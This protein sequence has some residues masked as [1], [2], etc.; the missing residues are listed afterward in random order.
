M[1]SSNT[2]IDQATGKVHMN[3]GR[4][5]IGVDTRMC[6]GEERVVA[7]C[8]DTN[9]PPPPPAYSPPAPANNPQG[10]RNPQEKSRANPRPMRLHA[11]QNTDDDDTDTESTTTDTDTDTDDECCRDLEAGALSTRRISQATGAYGSGNWLSPSFLCIVI[12]CMIIKILILLVIW[13]LVCCHR[14]H[15]CLDS[16]NGIGE[17]DPPMPSPHDPSP[18]M[19]SPQ[20]SQN[21]HQM[22]PWQLIA[23]RVHSIYHHQTQEHASHEISVGQYIA[24]GLLLSVL[25]GCASASG[26][27]F[28]V[29][30]SFVQIHQ[31]RPA[32][33]TSRPSSS[34]QSS[35]KSSAMRRFL[36]WLVPMPSRP[37]RGQ[38][39]RRHHNPSTKNPHAQQP[40]ST[41][42]SNALTTS[43]HQQLNGDGP[44]PIPVP[45]VDAT[46]PLRIAWLAIFL[47]AQ[48]A[49]TLA[50]ILL[51]AC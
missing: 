46:T 35:Q 4:W 25:G 22:R 43:P 50:F 26:L 32:S 44:R 29:F 9:S 15:P 27:L 24:A 33:S 41:P 38:G 23:E 36:A 42:T 8:S 16:G 2:G 19:P 14:Q 47:M 31:E 5:S 11:N 45:S 18:M 39:G 51:L 1:N 10:N 17:N 37:Q 13:W 6:D 20:S 30:L 49:I 28:A 34:R 21:P 48:G 40:S 12:R 7:T 3:I